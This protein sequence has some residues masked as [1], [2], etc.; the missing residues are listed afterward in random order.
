VGSGRHAGKDRRDLLVPEVY[1]HAA[2]GRRYGNG[3]LTMT[4]LLQPTNR[5]RIVTLCLLALVSSCT[6]IYNERDRSSASTPPTAPTPAVVVDVIEFRVFGNVGGAPVFIKYTNSVDGLTT[7]TAA[8]LP[9]V[10]TVRSD[11]SFIFL[12]LEASAVSAAIQLGTLQVQIYVNGKLFRE[13]FASGF[14]SLLAT[15]S[16]TYRR[17]K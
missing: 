11:D 7:A 2:D 8:T 9:Y 5:L 4:K 17:P 13:G 10:A 16:G 6:R 12:Y 14:A 1:G 15:A 3:V